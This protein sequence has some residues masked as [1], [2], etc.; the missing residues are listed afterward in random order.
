MRGTEH[1]WHLILA[2]PEKG[3]A[4]GDNRTIGTVPRHFVGNNY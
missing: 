1:M 3:K 4:N 2:R